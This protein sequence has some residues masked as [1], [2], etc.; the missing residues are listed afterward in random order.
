MRHLKTGG[1]GQKDRKLI[2]IASGSAT[3]SHWVRKRKVKFQ[4]VGKNVCRSL[5]AEERERGSTTLQEDSVNRYERAK[6]SQQV[7]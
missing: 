7:F 3:Q 5:A 6:S 4:V 2:Q 1:L